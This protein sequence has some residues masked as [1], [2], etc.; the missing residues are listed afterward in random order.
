MSGKDGAAAK[1]SSPLKFDTASIQ[2]R[3]SHLSAGKQESDWKRQLIEHDIRLQ[4]AKLQMIELQHENKLVEMRE[5]LYD[6][7]DK[8]SQ[9]ELEKQQI[10]RM[11]D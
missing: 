5:M 3:P 2:L 4:N 7:Q 1:K 8:N 6:L 9:I 11:K 10:M